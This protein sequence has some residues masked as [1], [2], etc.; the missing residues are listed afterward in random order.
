MT[1]HDEAEAMRRAAEARLQ[2]RR[3]EAARTEA[4][5]PRLVHE[6]QVHQ[7]ELEMQNSELCAART[8]L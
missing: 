6:L 4:D 8:E 5:L 7:I 3:A 2:A 1:S